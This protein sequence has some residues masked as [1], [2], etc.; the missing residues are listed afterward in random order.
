[1][2]NKEEWKDITRLEIID[3]DGRSY[4]NWKVQSIE[5]SIQDEGR[6]LK[7]FVKEFENVRQT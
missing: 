5:Q 3:A 2:K 1:M 6:T 7:L 4:T